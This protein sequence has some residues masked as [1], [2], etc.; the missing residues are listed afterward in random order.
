MNRKKVASSQ[1]ASDLFIYKTGLSLRALNNS[2][3]AML[4][5]EDVSF[6]W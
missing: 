1:N 3:I 5:S 6:M 2:D 4:S